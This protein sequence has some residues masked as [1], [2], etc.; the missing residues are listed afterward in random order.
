[1]KLIIIVA[2][3][4]SKIGADAPISWIAANCPAEVKLNKDNVVA[5]NVV[6]PDAVAIIPKVNDTDKYP[7]PMGNPS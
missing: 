4:T 2:R 6:R 1:R 7:K 3:K 5:C